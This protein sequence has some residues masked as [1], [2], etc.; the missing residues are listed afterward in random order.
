MIRLRPHDAF[1]AQFD[2][3]MAAARTVVA[4][5]E[6]HPRHAVEKKTVAIVEEAVVEEGDSRRPVR[7]QAS[8][9]EELLGGSV[10]YF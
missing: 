8:S 5:A 10:P 1:E 7:V 9:W 6:P 4:R 3:L 2:L